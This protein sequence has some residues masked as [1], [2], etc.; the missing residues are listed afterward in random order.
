[1]SAMPSS[2]SREKG[3]QLP[4]FF[5]PK[6]RSLLKRP[7][8]GLL[9]CIV[10]ALAVI[11]FPARP[12]H[13]GDDAATTVGDAADDAAITTAAE[14]Y[15]AKKGGEV[16]VRVPYYNT[17]DIPQN[18]LK[19]AGAR[20]FCKFTSKAD[21]SRIHVLL[22][23]LYAQ[24]PSLA[25]L[26]YYSKIPYNGSC[27]GNPASCYCSQLGGSDLFGGVNMNGGGWVQMTDP[28]DTVLEACIFPDLSS[29][30][31]WGLTYHQDN[32]IRGRNLKGALRFPDPYTKN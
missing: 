32:I 24:K 21:G 14:E 1:M 31:S 2:F 8:V 16:D 6:R 12:V 11:F 5:R 9:L 7:L 13:A 22:S 20:Y 28:V 26:A 30:D 4:R 19:L 29:I 3:V 10:F 17:N 18:W 25:A 27:N 15:C 23:T